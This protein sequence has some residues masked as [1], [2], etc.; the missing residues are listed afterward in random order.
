MHALNFIQLPWHP[1]H[2]MHPLTFH[3]NTLAFI[4]EEIYCKLN[5]AVETCAFSGSCVF[6]FH[7]SALELNSELYCF[8]NSATKTSSIVIYLKL[9]LKAADLHLQNEAQLR[10]ID[11]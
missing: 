6:G 3:C 8:V 7:M 2:E 1:Q 9:K 11:H 4:S 5:F 10:P